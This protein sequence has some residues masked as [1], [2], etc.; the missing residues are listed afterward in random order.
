ME[1]SLIEIKFPKNFIWGTATSAYQ[2][3]GAYQDD[4][5]GLS[6]WDV[7]CQEKGKIFNG[8]TGNIA[9]DHYHRYKDDLALL[10]E[11]NVN[12]YRF[13][14]SWPRILPR[15]KGKINENGIRFYENLINQLNEADIQPWV[16]LYHWDLPQ[17][18]QEKGGWESPDII[19]AFEEYTKVIGEKFKDKVAGWYILNEPFV[20]SF[21]GYAW[22]MHAP[23]KKSYDAAL[24]VAHHHLMAQ[25][26]SIMALRDILPKNVPVGTVVNVSNEVTQP[27]TQNR[28]NFLTKIK[29]LTRYWFL[30]PIFLG[31]YPKTDY[32]LPFKVNKDD[33]ELI[34]Q[35]IDVLGINYYSRS[36]WIPDE[37]REYFK[38]KSI[39]EQAFVTEK[40]WKIHPNGLFQTIK[41]LS[42]RYGKIPI[43]ITENG[44]AFEDIWRQGNPEI[45]QDDDRIIYIRDHLAEVLRA[46]KDGY[47]VTGY[48]YWSLLDNFEWADG[49]SMKFGIV[50]VDQNTLKRT[51]KKSFYYYKDVVKNNSFIYP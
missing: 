22:G 24:K 29:N 23:G 19:N 28:E 25:G 46:I 6:I 2:I 11:L 39:P 9:C 47:N 5:K 41:E 44:A 26:K 4:E 38:G 15:G 42:K 17:A 30:D 13:S 40:K 8:D 45:I 34:H 12:A 33:M 3:E 36:I 1:N 18:L 35:K 10:K 32:K 49:Y 14:I 31:E 48:F 7:F 20:S 51:P 43:Q 50:E 27:S 21:L 37:D 16:T